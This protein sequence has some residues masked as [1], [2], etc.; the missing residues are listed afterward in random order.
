[1]MQRF[2]EQPR[3][4]HIGVPRTHLDSHEELAAYRLVAGF[5]IGGMSALALI[6]LLSLGV[7]R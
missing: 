3:T 1:M 2:D 4:A 5:L 6:F 7:L